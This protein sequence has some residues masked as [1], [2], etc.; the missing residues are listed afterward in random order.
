MVRRLR[1]H[2]IDG[3]IH[4]LAW[5]LWNSLHNCFVL[6]SIV[7]DNINSHSLN[8]HDQ[9]YLSTAIH[10]RLPRNIPQESMLLH[11]KHHIQYG[12]HK[13]TRRSHLN[14]TLWHS[15]MQMLLVMSA[16][17]FIC[18][19]ARNTACWW[20]GRRIML[21]DNWLISTALFALKQ[22]N[23]FVSCTVQVGLNPNNRS[24][25]KSL[26]KSISTIRLRH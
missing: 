3:L 21:H 26:I 2:E 24:L 22:S 16:A 23:D 20:D 6:C 25:I 8:W 12:V 1:S 18:H 7:S 14:R 15:L 4:D 13:R 19:V 5:G 11:L 10:Y 17:Y 9:K